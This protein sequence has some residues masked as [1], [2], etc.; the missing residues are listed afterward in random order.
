VVVLFAAHAALFGSWTAHIPEVKAHLA[1]TDAGLGMAL[2][3]APIGALAAMPVTGRLLARFD[4]RRVIRFTLAGYCFTAVGVGL[5][6]SQ[7]WLFAALAL[8]GAF[9]GSLDVSMNTQGITVERALGRPVM[10]G[11]H[12]A[13]S[14]G[15]FLGAGL[16]AVA[17]AV[18]VSLAGQLLG[19]GLVAAVVAGAASSRMLPDPP[20]QHGRPDRPGQ[21]RA[22]RVL[23]HPVVLVLGAVALACMLCEG[24]AAD[25]SAVYLHDSLRASPAVAALGYAAFSATMVGLR[26]GGDRLLARVPVRTLLPGLAAVSTLGLTSALMVRAPVTALLGFAALG[27]GLAL[28]VPAAF[29]AAGRLPGIHPGTAVAAVSALGWVGFVG[30][31]PLI[32]RLA[33]LA[34]LP[35]A[36]AILPLLTAAIAVVTRTTGVFA[37]PSTP[38]TPSSPAPGPGAP[39]SDRGLAAGGP[40]RHEDH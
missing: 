6:G 14:V 34:S 2:L 29:S 13:W 26:L 15:G 39:P 22:I 17:V 23:R 12:G 16:G 21:G 32:G 18:G 20:S 5:A 31:P 25:W 36:L 3:G 27:V 35:V 40:G 9:Q 38:S 24:A 10:S 7:R 19:F 1:L 33:D 8:W 28:I 30:G 37:P 4:S 11:F